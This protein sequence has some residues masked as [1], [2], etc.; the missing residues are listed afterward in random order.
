MSTTLTRPTVDLVERA[1]LSASNVDEASGVIRNVKI[2]G[3]TSRNNRRYLP[4]AL[5]RAVGRYE[6][7][8][9]FVDHPRR[10]EASEVRSYRDKVGT[11]RGVRFVEN[12]L[13]GDLHVNLEHPVAKQLL[14][15]AKHN[16]SAV[17]L[18]HNARGKTRTEGGVVVVEEI[19]DLV[20]V[21]LVVDPA[22]TSGLFESRSVDTMS[23]QEFA[24]RLLEAD[25]GVDYMPSMADMAKM[26]EEL[27]A[28]K[29]EVGR[30]LETAKTVDEL[31]DKLQ[32]ILDAR[33]GPPA[34]PV[35]TM[36]A[37]ESLDP[38][39][40]ASAITENVRGSRSSSGR[41]RAAEFAAALFD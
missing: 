33:M 20:S 29:N 19:T 40:F 1:N 16:P 41:D 21:D 4:E 14:W 13:R 30:V 31:V 18:S 23:S 11:L 35:V 32:Q 9:V 36:P 12:A 34:E 8:G 10:S 7:K 37:G 3:P 6:G 17:G 24:K 22:S 38:Y 28:L 26:P 5:R 25:G 27:S 15:D 2:I 39:A